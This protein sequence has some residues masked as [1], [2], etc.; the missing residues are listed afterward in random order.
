MLDEKSAGI[1]GT[2]LII[3][4]LGPR[5]HS[6]NANLEKP[7]IQSPQKTHHEGQFIGILKGETKIGETIVSEHL[8]TCTIP[9]C[10]EAAVTFICAM[11]HG[12]SDG[13]E[14]SQG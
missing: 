5:E 11:G 6:G 14:G 3:D 12:S 13:C 8:T 10:N 4:L 9:W 1:P 7:D 2:S